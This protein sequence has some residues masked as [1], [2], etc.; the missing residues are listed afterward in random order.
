MKAEAIVADGEVT[1]LHQQISHLVG[2][3]QG[4]KDERMNMGNRKGIG[5][6]GK[7]KVQR[8]FYH[9]PIALA[10]KLLRSDPESSGGKKFLENGGKLV[11][12]GG[13]SN[14]GVKLAKD[15]EE[16]RRTW[17]GVR[18]ADAAGAPTRLQL[19]VAGD[20]GWRKL[21]GRSRTSRRGQG[22]NPQ[23]SPGTSP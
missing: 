20:D 14:R 19:G 9:K 21:F 11:E 10:P 23:A 1:V 18:R 15:K 13:E 8:I 4:G 16:E 7:I 6:G 17:A 5:A 2:S 12:N 22:G 3:S